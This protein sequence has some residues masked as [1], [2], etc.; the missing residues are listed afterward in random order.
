[1]KNIAIFCDGTWNQPDQHAERAQ[2][3][4]NVVK[5][6]SLISPQ[7]QQGR[8]QR[9][10]YHAGIGAGSHGFRR[11][12]EGATGQGI[13][14]VVKECYRWL[15]RNYAPGDALFLFGFSRG[16][17]TARSLAGFIRNSGVLRPENQDKLDDAFALYRSRSAK[18]APRAVASMLFRR[19]YSWSVDTPIACIGVWDT[20]GSLGVP[21]RF[22][23]WVVRN[24]LRTNIEFHDTDLSSTVANA[25]HAIATDDERKPFLPTLWTQTERGRNAGQRLEQ[26]W[27]AGW[28]GD[29]GGGCPGSGLSDTTLTWMA[30]RAAEAGL[31][32]NPLKSLDPAT[33]ARFAPETLAPTHR[34]ADFFY[35]LALGPG[36]RTI[37]G[38]RSTGDEAL[39]TSVLE[40]WNGVPDW[41]TP[42][43]VD[44]CRRRPELL[45]GVDKLVD[46]RLGG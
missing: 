18:T 44:L 31:E 41:R 10:F 4:T 16:A 33:L 17:Y 43:V 8:E 26:C 14:L 45:G 5:L 46:A 38:G 21:N 20:V 13:D 2:F 39:H 30:A 3:P 42:A 32:V 35:R 9:V 28:H 34:A 24:A 22:W 6:A 29:V 27:F 23:Q 40:R 36:I 7:T 12:F 25:F 15:A 11:A 19:S 1:M 37:L